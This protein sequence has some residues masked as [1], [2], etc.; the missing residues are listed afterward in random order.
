MTG[1]QWKVRPPRAL[2]VF[3]VNVYLDVARILGPTSTLD[4]FLELAVKHANDPLPH[5][6]DA[7]LDSL[8][9]LAISKSGNYAPGVR[10]EIWFGQHLDDT[11]YFKLIQGTSAGDHQEDRG[12]GWSADDANDFMERLVEPFWKDADT[13]VAGD[14]IGYE[15]P[16]LD[17]EDGCVYATARDAGSEEYF[18]ERFCVTRDADFRNAALNG[19][20]EVMHPHEWVSHVRGKISSGNPM[21]KMAPKRVD[22][23][24]VA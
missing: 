16:P 8:R 9:A 20:I 18:Y 22:A 11:T 5:H 4:T 17:H 10:L 19:D 3:D 24:S 13:F 6:R 23:T 15:T 12:F 7:A 21:T 14:P 2:V 1:N